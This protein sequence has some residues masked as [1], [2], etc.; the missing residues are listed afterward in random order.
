MVNP[1]NNN[2]E[3]MVNYLEFTEKLNANLWF[4]TILYP[5]HLSIKYESIDNLNRIY[6]TMKAQLSVTRK[7]YRNYHVF[8]HLVEDQ[9]ANWLL[10]AM[11]K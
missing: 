10:D 7:S 6:K 1:M 5:K 8:E 3:E 2:Y 9:I 11:E 4:N